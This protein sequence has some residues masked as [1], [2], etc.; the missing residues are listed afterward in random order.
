MQ[1]GQPVCTDCGD[2]YTGSRC[3]SVKTTT[4]AEPPSTTTDLICTYLPNG[5]CNK[6][7]CAVGQNAQ[8]YCQC[9]P[10]YTGDRCQTASGSRMTLFF[11]YSLTNE[12]LFVN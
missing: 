3:Q 10:T 1:S 5:Y 8:V 11:F 2:K 7:T 9:P 12:Q 6:G 4:T